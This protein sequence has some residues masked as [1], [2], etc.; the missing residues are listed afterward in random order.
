ML[1]PCPINNSYSD[2]CHALVA[3]LSTHHTDIFN[4]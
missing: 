1:S 3:A 2:T 4:S